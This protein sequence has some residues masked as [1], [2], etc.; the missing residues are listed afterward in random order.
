MF[1]FLFDWFGSLSRFEWMENLWQVPKQIFNES[2]YELEN[3]AWHET[4]HLLGS[5]IVKCPCFHVHINPKTNN[6]FV[7]Y[8]NQSN[9][10]STEQ[11]DVM[12]VGGWAL[13]RKH[14]DLEKCKVSIGYGVQQP[15]DNEECDDTLSDWNVLGQPSIEKLEDMSELFYHD[16]LLEFSKKICDELVEKKRFSRKDILRLYDEF[17]SDS[18]LRFIAEG[19]ER[20]FTEQFKR[21]ED[22]E[23]A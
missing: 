4:G 14:Y 23:S 3:S 20:A 9:K 18:R 2:D 13:E 15:E 11:F 19:I 1:D 16:E 7:I 10:L 17:M 8:S 12:H 22:N 5:F 6:A 21:S